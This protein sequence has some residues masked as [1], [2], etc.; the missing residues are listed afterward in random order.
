[1]IRNH[2]KLSLYLHAVRL[3]PVVGVLLLAACSADAP[4]AAPPSDEPLHLSLRLQVPEQMTVSTRTT[5][6]P[7]LKGI[8]IK[9]VRAIQFGTNNTANKYYSDTDGTGNWYEVET[10]SGLVVI[11]TG[12][13]DFLNETGNI[14][15]IV[16]GGDADASLTKTDMTENDLQTAALSL[17][18]FSTTEEP[19]LL[20]YGPV[21]FTAQSGTVNPVAMLA[22]MKRAYAKVTVDYTVHT[23]VSITSVEVQNMPPAICPF[24][25]AGNTTP[26]DKTY[27]T[28]VLGSTETSTPLP[29]SFT[30]YMP[31][32]L[33]GNGSATTEKDKNRT[34]YGPKETVSGSPVDCLD[35]CT[36][37]VLKGTYSYPDVTGTDPISVEYRFYLGSDMVQNYDVER[38]KHYQLTV[39]LLGA[40]SAD[41]RVTITD[42]NVFAVADP[43]NVDHT[44]EIIF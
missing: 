33:R 44:D 28:E 24:T 8:E 11:A 38:G 37:I 32:N 30:F 3:L 34:E 12:E 23:G 43:D 42:S 41:A 40:N 14:Y 35:Y 27:R 29:K 25:A 6:N 20:V 26:R 39:D 13:S 22:R 21:K 5:V 15:I 7:T 2:C 4:P 18:G 1:M 10:E 36:C 16:N 19:Q 17:T 9:N 31:E